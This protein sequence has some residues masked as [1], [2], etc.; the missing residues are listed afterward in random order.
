MFDGVL[1]T[2]LNSNKNCIRRWTQDNEPY[3]ERLLFQGNYFFSYL[4]ILD[5]KIIL[6][7]HQANVIYWTLISNLQ[8][9]F[10]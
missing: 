2:P 1:N 5:L 6:Y 3:Q 4:F 9:T 7:K 10:G 8:F